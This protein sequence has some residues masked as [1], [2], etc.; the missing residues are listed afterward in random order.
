MLS[1]EIVRSMTD[2]NYAYHRRVWD[3]VMAL[4]GDQFTQ[5]LPYSHGS[6]RN[7]M[8]HLASTDGGWLRGLKEIPNARAFQYDPEDYPTPESARALCE[9]TAEEVAA[10]VAALD[11]AAL[12]RQPQ[13]LPTTVWQTLLH[14]V[15]HGTDHRAQILRALHDF[16]A[17]TFD[18]D[19]AF[20]FMGR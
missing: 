18:Q 8:V 13:G 11:E 15:N 2:Y 4:T 17:D 12:Q 6:I 1:V 20:Y 3:S 7:Q 9:N 10:Y 14:L 16:G 19:L 5:D